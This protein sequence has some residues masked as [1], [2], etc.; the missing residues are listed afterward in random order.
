LI[1]GLLGLL[2]WLNERRKGNIDL[3]TMSHSS[4]ITLLQAAQTRLKIVEDE[5]SSLDAQYDKE[6]ARRREIEDSLAEER[7]LIKEYSE[8]IKE[9]KEHI[10]ALE[11]QIKELKDK[12]AALEEKNKA[13]LGRTGLE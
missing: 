10:A 6:K 13:D 8:K 5:L 4:A 3:L 9:L 1:P 7:R 12:L 11:A 2:S